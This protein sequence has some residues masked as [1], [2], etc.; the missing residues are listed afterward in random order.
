MG[1]DL[2]FVLI[3]TCLGI[4]KLKCMIIL[5]CEKIHLMFWRVAGYCTSHLEEGGVMNPN[6]LLSLC[7]SLARL[8]GTLFQLNCQKH[9][10]ELVFVNNFWISR[11]YLFQGKKIKLAQFVHKDSTLAQIV[12]FLFHNL[13][14]HDNKLVH[15]FISE[16]VVN[17]GHI[18]SVFPIL[19]FI[20]KELHVTSIIFNKIMQDSGL[21]RSNIDV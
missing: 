14:V 3:L 16:H 8:P 9:S 5:H 17:L 15:F 18:T 6:M 2:P 7:K 1:V 19:Q 11:E 13:P 20:G 10:H 21:T 12:W 4:I